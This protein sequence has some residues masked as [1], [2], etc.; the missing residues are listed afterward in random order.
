MRR[1]V[2]GVI[3][4]F[5]LMLALPGYNARAEETA[6]AAKTE[7]VAETAENAEAAETVSEEAEKDKTDK[8]NKKDKKDKSDADNA[9]DEDDEEDEDEF[10]AYGDMIGSISTADSATEPLLKKIAK[11]LGETDVD[12]AFTKAAKKVSWKDSYNK[13]DL[14]Y[15]SCI[16]YC[17]A[18]GMSHEAQVAVGNVILNRMRSPEWSH[19]NT[20]KEVIYDRKWGTQFSPTSIKVDKKGTTYMDRTLKIYDSMDPDKFKSW[21]ITAMEKC[22]AVAKEVLTGTKAV[23]DSYIYFNGYVTSTKAKCEA[24]GWSYI[25]I[26]GH[27]YYVQKSR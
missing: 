25:I 11:M 19:V 9:D 22:I 6:E 24:K 15:L 23:P 14:R 20:I 26:E 3:A 18:N 8:K 2:I 7:E 12:T 16:I 13:E 27:I 10:P 17:E 21:E 5:M 4:A 1:F